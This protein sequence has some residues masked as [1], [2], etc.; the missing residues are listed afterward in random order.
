[1]KKLLLGA[2][3]A[4][5]LL[6]GVPATAGA[7]TAPATVTLLHA[8]PGVVVDVFVGGTEVIPDFQPDATFD[9]SAFAGSTLT[10]VEVKA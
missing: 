10:D 7:Q 5:A 4:S 6:I 9:L 1:M 8:I 3:A 2:L